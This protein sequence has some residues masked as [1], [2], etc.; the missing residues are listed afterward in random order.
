MQ[1]YDLFSRI[2]VV[3]ALDSTAISTSTTTVGETIDT[4]SCESLVF[5][6]KSETLT[7]GAYAVQVFVSDDSG[8]AGE[9]QVIKDYDSADTLIS[10]AISFALA[11]DNIVKIVGVVSGKRYARIKI[12]STAVTTGGTFS[13]TAIKG[14]KRHIA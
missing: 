5:A 3:N 13:A 10:S 11:D 7:D 14:N 9:V 12:V 6:I 2:E 8:M 1:A 4:S